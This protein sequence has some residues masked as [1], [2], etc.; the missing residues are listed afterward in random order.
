MKLLRTLEGHKGVVNGVAFDPR[1]GLLAS[2]GNDSTVRTW[3]VESGELLRTLKG[4]K[5]NARSVAFDPRGAVLASGGDKTVRLWD[6]ESGMLLSTLEGHTGNFWSVAFDPRGGAL[7]SGGNETVRLWDLESGE[8]R[9]L[10][11][12]REYVYSVAFDP[13][14][15]VLASG[16]Y[17]K[18]VRLWYTD[19]GKLLHTLGHTHAVFSVAFDP[20]GSV[21]ASGG[22]DKTVRLWDPESGKLMRTLEGH[23]HAV[24]ALAFCQK[25]ALL[26]SKS[27]DGTVRLWSRQSWECIAI[28]PVPQQQFIN[29]AALCFHPDRPILATD[30]SA[31]TLEDKHNSRLIRFWE[32]DFDILLGHGAGRTSTESTSGVANPRY[33]TVHNTTAKIVLVGDSGV[34]KTGLGWRLA[35]GEYREHDSTHG[36]QFWVLGQLAQTR[37]DGTQCEAVLWDLAGQPDYRLIHALSIQD[38]DLA[39]ILFDP[40]NTR[41]P[42]GSAEYWL[43]Q[44]PPECPKILVAARV[45]R[46]HPVLTREELDQFCRRQGIAGGWVATSAASGLG[47]DDLLDRMKRAIPWDDKPAVST[48]AVFKRIKDFVLALKENRTRKQIIFS[49]AE[50]REELTS[51][52]PD[53]SARRLPAGTLESLTDA[54]LLTAV[55]HLSSQGFVRL[56]MLST[57]DE[58]ILLVPELLNNLAS[59]IVLEARRNS[60]GLG[61]V[62]ESRLLDNSYRFRELEVLSESDRA[63]LLDGTITAFLANRLSY[64]CFREAWGDMR[65]L[66][67]PDLMNLKKPERDDLVTEDGPLYVLTGSTE[68]TFASLVVLLGYTNLFLRTDQAQDVAWFTTDHNDLCGVRQVRDD[69]ERTLVLL[70]SPTLGAQVRAV[71][72]GLVEQVLSRRSVNVRRLRPVRC[73]RC[74]TPVDR[75]VMIRRMKLGKVNVFCEECGN[76]V[77]YPPDEPLS[78][79]PA[80]RRAITH[81]GAV[82]ERRTRFEEVIYELLRLAQAE[83]RPVPTCFVSYAREN[84]EYERWVERRLAS[85]LEKAGIPVV[86]ER[87]DNAHLGASGSRFVGRVEQADRVLIVGTPAY[88]RKYENQVPNTEA[89]VAAEADL[90]SARLLGTE[91][92]KASVTLLLL[93]GEPKES[94]PPALQTDVYFDFRNDDRYFDTALDLL[95]ALYRIDPRH[96]AAIHWKQRLAKDEFSR[97]GPDG[98]T[99]DDDQSPVESRMRLALQQVGRQSLDAAFAIQKSVVVE[100]DGRLVR[101]H[102]DGTTTPYDPQ[103]DGTPG[104]QP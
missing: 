14:G 53:Q 6:V 30:A 44:L 17:D 43:R 59:S 74:G 86:L 85:D 52:R 39:L 37:K 32:L 45:D 20:R 68:N 95:L 4:Q 72:E 101:L 36:Q 31:S 92:E 10:E 47:L 11:A 16:G 89:V 69:T 79:R 41:D 15:G 87:G 27:F 84:A 35:H 42:L 18:K 21:L 29:V 13:R 94:L 34:G 57:G 23:T 63:L 56:L 19:G 5:N 22:D 50:L 91:A 82:A 98:E 71:F 76:S 77:A 9:T 90:I 25:A 3:D 7:A 26:A 103:S 73:S 58:R 48:D 61:A 70:F 66:V 102:A 60:R 81:E 55:R 96:P 49:T 38:A 93:A 2:S 75:V 97:R 104:P 88:R 78:V 99:E 12:H 54:Q 100:Q 1:G 8:L 80:D 51:N 33:Q 83:E 67:F 62:E 40:T 46:G 28:I 24:S 65:L 64:R